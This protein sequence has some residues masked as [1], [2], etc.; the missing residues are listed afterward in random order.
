[1]HLSE[2][3][4]RPFGELCLPVGQLCDPWPV[5]VIR[6]AQDFKDLEELPNLHAASVSWP[7]CEVLFARAGE[8]ITGAL[9]LHLEGPSLA[10]H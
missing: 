8:A 9:Q 4:G 1:M 7:S 3:F 6:S 5:P 10:L 2:V